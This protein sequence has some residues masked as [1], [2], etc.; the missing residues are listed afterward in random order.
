MKTYIP[1]GYSSSLDLYETQAAIALIKRTFQD[2]LTSVL[3]LKRVSAPLFVDPTTGMNDNL[4]G[5][6]RAVRFDIPYIDKDA[7][8]VQSLAKWKRYALYKYN[9]FPGNGLYTDMNAIRRD[10]GLDNL[11]SLYVDQWDWEKVITREERNEETLRHIVKLIVKCICFSSEVVKAKYRMLDNY[12]L[13]SNVSFIT[14]QELLDMY[15][16][17]SSDQREYEYV[18]KHKTAFIMHIG[19][20]LSNGLPHDKRSPDYDDWQLNGDL[21][22]Y[23]PVLD[24]AFEISSMGIRVDAASLESQLKKAGCEERA[25]MMYHTMVKNGVLPL[26]VGGGIGQSRLC[27]LLTGKAHIGEVQASLWDEETVRLCEERG[28]QLL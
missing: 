15:P 24:C 9:F 8:V 27:M 19:D 16:N 6:E 17:L 11:H 20:T 26:T 21:I 25:G 4:S 5:V 14:S 13:E 18:K 22:F 3:S 12:E 10:E 28:V 23:Y 1:E 2:T 7:E